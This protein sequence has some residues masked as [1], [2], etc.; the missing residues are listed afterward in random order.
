MSAVD[1]A[2]SR[3]RNSRL[4]NDTSARSIP[5]ADRNRERITHSLATPTSAPATAA[6]TPDPAALVPCCAP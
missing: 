1:A 6:P 4:Q 3:D 5:A 2:A